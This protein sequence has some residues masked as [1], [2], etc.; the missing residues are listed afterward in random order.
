LP[1]GNL[2]AIAMAEASS[3][4]PNEH[5]WTAREIAKAA[6]VGSVFVGVGWR[7]QTCQHPG[8]P[9]AEA[10]VGNKTVRIWVL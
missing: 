7:G 5:V 9:D 8:R 2:H 10:T 1:S 6:G 3:G 4:A